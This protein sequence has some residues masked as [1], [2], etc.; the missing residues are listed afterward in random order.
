MSILLLGILGALVWW[1]L[2]SLRAREAAL[3]ACRRACAREQVQLLDETVAVRRLGLARD[4]SGR[5]RVRRSYGFEFS[6]DG[7]DRRQGEAI[8][9]G[10][11]PELVR[12]DWPRDAEAEPASE[13]PLPGRVIPFRG[14]D[15]TPRH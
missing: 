3:K 12:A 11:S 14:R 10:Q 13:A 15:G 9:L 5:V 1:W 8:C 2:A 4:S 6:V 7:H